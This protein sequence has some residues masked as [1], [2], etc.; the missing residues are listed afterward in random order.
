MAEGDLEAVEGVRGVVVGIAG[1]AI[2]IKTE[3]D[4]HYQESLME[5]GSIAVTTQ[6]MST[7]DSP[8]HSVTP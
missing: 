7:E 5:G 2:G 6:P 4:Q 8:S 1:I 3:D